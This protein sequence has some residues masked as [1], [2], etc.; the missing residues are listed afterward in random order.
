MYTPLNEKYYFFS[1][2]DTIIDIL[3]PFN[4]PTLVGFLVGY[5]LFSWDIP[6]N[7]H[8]IH[9]KCGFLAYTKEIAYEP[10]TSFRKSEK[11]TGTALMAARLLRY[12]YLLADGIY[13]L[14]P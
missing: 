3:F 11:E 2:Y 1:L 8:K 12:V 14:F 5:P 4:H 7:T 6:Q 13:L 9:T 10:L